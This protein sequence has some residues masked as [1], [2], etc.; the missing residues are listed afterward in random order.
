MRARLTVLLALLGLATA[1]GCGQQNYACAGFCA[2][3]SGEFEGVIPAD[4]FAD[5]EN[6]CNGK[7]QCITGT[8]Y[9]Q[10]YPMQ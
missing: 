10:C 4:G 2:D 1:T 5:A 9:C 7:Y 8:K 6:Q 3:G